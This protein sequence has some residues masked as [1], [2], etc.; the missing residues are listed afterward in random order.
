MKTKAN[1][2]FKILF[3][4]CFLLIFMFTTQR[5]VEA[6]DTNKYL[7]VGLTRELGKKSQITIN[8]TSVN[9]GY[10]YD[11][12]N[13]LPLNITGNTIVAKTVSSNYLM[14]TESATTAEAIRSVQDYYTS[15]E[16][17]TI[18]YMTSNSEYRLLI[19]PFAT[20]QL[21]TDKSNELL[22]N[23][24]IASNV[25]TI[26]NKVGFEVDGNIEVILG[27]D[28][29]NPQAISADSGEFTTISNTY[30]Y[31]GAIEFLPNGGSIQPINVV[32]LEQY[33]YGVVPSEMP[34][35]WHNEALKAQ[36]IAA[37]T[38]TLSALNISKHTSDGYHIC[39]STHCQVYKGV[40]NEQSSTNAAIDATKGIA[41]YYNNELIEAL[42]SASNGGSTAN[43]EDVWSTTIP[44]LRAKEDPYDKGS[45]VWTREFS[46]SELNSLVK[47]KNS[48]LGEVQNVK[49]DKTD[50][51]GRAVSLTFECAN[52]D[53]IVEKDKI[54]T[55]FSGTSEGSLKSTNFKITQNLT[56]TEIIDSKDI[57][58]LVVLGASGDVEFNIDMNIISSIN[59]TDNISDIN[60]TD[61]YI[62]G[63]ENVLEYLEEDEEIITPTGSLV[64]DGEGWGHGVGLSQW[65]AKGMAEKNFSYTEILEFYY[66]GVELK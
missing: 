62:K 44:Y 40:N 30:K 46:Q 34:A 14:L 43:A 20:E 23:Q 52:G 59:G 53:Y 15:L 66:T 8:N 1:N 48:S 32:L 12:Y 60:S 6:T 2:Y 49:I 13:T 24:S 19:G 27:S 64:L 41:L 58:D 57:N 18:I 42:F 35:S 9:V 50:K 47:A 51:Y 31:R 45:V 17:P 54:R 33:L 36:S 28:S 56:N 22:A 3:V 37:R 65:G 38:Y 39:D 4:A 29:S 55:F 11:N 16:I 10:G 5:V 26:S 61:I 63:S 25:I 7:K 21:A